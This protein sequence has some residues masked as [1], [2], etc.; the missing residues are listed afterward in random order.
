[1]KDKVFTFSAVLLPI[2]LFTLIF[3]FI[4][5]YM[6]NER[7]VTYKPKE[8]TV[9]SMYFNTKINYSSNSTLPLTPE[10][11]IAGVNNKFSGVSNDPVEQI[12]FPKFEESYY[13]SSVGGEM[14][15]T[16]NT[17]KF[18]V[19]YN[20]TM[21]HSIPATVNALSNAYLASKNINDRITI[22]NHS[23]DKSQNTVANIGLTFVG[24]IL[25]MSIVTILN[26]FGPLSA[27]ERINQLLLQLQLNGVSR[28]SYWI[29]NLV[30]DNGIFL[31]T[32]ILLI[33][34]GVAVRFKPLLDVKIVLLVIG[35]LII[36]SIPMMLFQYILS[37]FFKK[38]DTAYSRITAINI[39]LIFIGF[40]GL[41]FINTNSTMGS[42]L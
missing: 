23:W 4:N 18:N 35:F 28:I 6:F 11:N 3:Y 41:I 37:F 7:T 26:K 16:T 39:C 31:T 27:R 8:V 17:F 42:T 30:T 32:C 29:S 5:K 2:I 34:A 38:E 13:L 12:K 9:P 21:P 36:W 33:L 40:M 20:D 24:L 10:N 15:S 19:F 22:I 1:M 25:G 14:D